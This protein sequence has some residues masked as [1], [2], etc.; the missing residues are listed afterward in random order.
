MDCLYEQGE[1]AE[2]KSWNRGL[3]IF[4]LLWKPSLG[5]YGYTQKVPKES[6][7]I[8]QEILRVRFIIL[9]FLFSIFFYTSYL[10]AN[11][12]AKIESHYIV[13]DVCIAMDT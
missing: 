8:L 1:Y 5:K 12:F 6:E 11:Y 13:A 2:T 4:W 10:T 9:V 3:C 7:C